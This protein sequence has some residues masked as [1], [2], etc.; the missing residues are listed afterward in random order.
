MKKILSLMLCF[1]LTGLMCIPAFALPVNDT[2]EYFE[3]GSYITV[4]IENPPENENS[5]TFFV[6][7]MEFF[8]KLV[9]F[10]TG[11]NSVSKVKYINYYSSDGRHL[12][13][14]YLKA[15]F[16]YTKKEAICTDARFRME[17]YDND[18]SLSDSECTKNQNIAEAVFTVQQYKL[19]VPLKT[20]T[21]NM[22][23]TC[24]ASG[25]VG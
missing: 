21:K 24:D 20:I 22:T 18:W 23:L 2:R 3:D 7:L 16:T 10:F 25:N 15:D 8:R 9:E 13:S 17:I 6:R 4:S 14:A 19:L 12:W 5:M 11:R 1:F